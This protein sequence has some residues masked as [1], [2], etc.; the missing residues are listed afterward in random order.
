MKHLRQAVDKKYI[1]SFWTEVKSALLKESAWA[2]LPEWK[3]TTAPTGRRQWAWKFKCNIFP[4]FPSLFQRDAASYRNSS[5]VSSM[6]PNESPC[7]ITEYCECKK[8]GVWVRYRMWRGWGA[9]G[10][11]HSPL[12]CSLD[13]DGREQPGHCP[14]LPPGCSRAE[15]A[16]LC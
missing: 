6:N 9:L 2:K 11:S 13:V 5:D 16:A 12:L 3:K 7:S 15:N 14:L 10:T 1:K 4:T 8:W